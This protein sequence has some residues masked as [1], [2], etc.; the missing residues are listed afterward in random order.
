M[1]DSVSA[2]VLGKV[3]PELVRTNEEQIESIRKHLASVHSNYVAAFDRLV[4][5]AQEQ[6]DE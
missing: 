2:A 5:L 3:N 4:Q 1:T 6:R